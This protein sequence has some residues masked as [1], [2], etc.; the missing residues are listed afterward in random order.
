VADCVGEVHEPIV[1]GPFRD[2]VGHNRAERKVGR[3][4]RRQR[5]LELL[6]EFR[7]LIEDEFDMLT[8]VLLEGRDGLPDRLVLL[9]VE[10]LI[11]PHH[12]VGGLRAERCQDQHHGQNYDS[13]AHC[14][15]FPMGVH[16]EHGIV[17]QRQRRG[18]R[19]LASKD[20]ARTALV[21]TGCFRMNSVMP[22]CMHSRLSL[23][24]SIRALSQSEDRRPSSAQ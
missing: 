24:V 18:P 7:L 9:R 19:N 14:D 3:S 20:M 15:A 8:A 12:E 17:L 16:H 10:P 11:P 5:R 1:E 4:A 13:A 6:R 23:S 21:E 22:A 2:V